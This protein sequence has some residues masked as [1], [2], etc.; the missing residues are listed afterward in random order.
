M[1]CRLKISGLT[2]EVY[3]HKLNNNKITLSKSI[4]DAYIYQDESECFIDRKIII[5]QLPNECRFIFD[6]IN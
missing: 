6:F 4:D 1:K 5:P 3:T 2:D